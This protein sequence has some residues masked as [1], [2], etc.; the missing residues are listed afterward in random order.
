M[1]VPSVQNAQ[2]ITCVPGHLLAGTAG[3]LGHH[4][5]DVIP[6]IACG[7]NPNLL[8]LAGQVSGS[9]QFVVRSAATPI[10]GVT[11][12]KANFRADTVAHAVWFFLGMGEHGQWQAKRRQQQ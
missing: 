4:I 10:Q 1:L 2:H 5:L 9:Y 8:E 7:L 6:V 3:A 11:G 12:Q